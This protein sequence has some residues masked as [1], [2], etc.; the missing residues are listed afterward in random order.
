MSE[1]QMNVIE[2]AG[3]NVTRPSEEERPSEQNS[4]KTMANAVFSIFDPFKSKHKVRG[5]WL[6]LYIVLMPVVFVG[7]LTAML[8]QLL[9]ECTLESSTWTGFTDDNNWKQ[10]FQQNSGYVYCGAQ[11]QNTYTNYE[12]TTCNLFGM[13]PQY[14]NLALPATPIDDDF[15]ASC[16]YYAHGDD[17]TVIVVYYEVCGEVHH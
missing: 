12:F 4:V 16:F 15:Q 9:N 7:V 1:N 2:N 13:T 3:E 5:W 17:T 11:Y 10:M 6:V 8:V 14:C